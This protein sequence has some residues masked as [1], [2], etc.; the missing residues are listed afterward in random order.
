MSANPQPL[1]D[2]ASIMM[3]TL[4]GVIPSLIIIDVVKDWINGKG[5]KKAT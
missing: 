3:Y 2:A 1:I 5:Q 4:A